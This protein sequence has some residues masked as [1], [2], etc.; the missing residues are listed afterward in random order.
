MHWHLLRL[1]VVNLLVFEESTP[2]SQ[3]ERELWLAL[4][5][6]ERVSAWEL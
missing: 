5:L 6:S 2:G 4:Q 1:A 3:W